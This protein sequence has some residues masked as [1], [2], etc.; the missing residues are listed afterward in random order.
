MWALRAA[1]PLEVILILS[2]AAAWNRGGETRIAIIRDREALGR[3]MS[4]AASYY[5]PDAE[6]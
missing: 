2:T 4:I 3:S 5:P 1:A 6:A